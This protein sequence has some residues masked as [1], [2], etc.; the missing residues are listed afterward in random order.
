MSDSTSIEPTAAPLSG[1]AWRVRQASGRDAAAVAGGVEKLLVEL[2]GKCPSSQAL[3]AEAQTLVDDPGAGAAF[4]AE[5]GGAL[6]GLLVASR[7]RAMHVPGPYFLIQDLWVDR[8]WR[9]RKIGADLL[10]AMADLAQEQ[11]IARIEVGLPRESFVSFQA[12]EAFYARNGFEPLGL[13]MRR[14]LDD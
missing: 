11:G 4:V 6:V 8:E 1:S 10:A 13:R 5:A 12:T 14:V 3:E 2:G 7:Q 9:S